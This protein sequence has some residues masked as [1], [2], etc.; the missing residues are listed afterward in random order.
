[1]GRTRKEKKDATSKLIVTQKRK[2]N[3][4]NVF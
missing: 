1:M 4:Q 3:N 2:N